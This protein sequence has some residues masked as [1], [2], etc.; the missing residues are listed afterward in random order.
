MDETL[1][2]LKS[3]SDR[4]RLRIV[5]ALS[6]FEELCA[7]QVTELLQI[8]GASVSRHLSLLTNSTL[9]KSRKQGRWVFFRLNQEKVNQKLLQWIQ[10]QLSNDLQIETDRS[11]LTA[12][13]S[14]PPEEICRK[15][16]GEACCPKK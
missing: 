5:A 10:L 8:S 9:L 4:N 1:K 15:Q 3:I 13:L 2:I 16:R 7:C 6:R 14:V 12:I 11:A